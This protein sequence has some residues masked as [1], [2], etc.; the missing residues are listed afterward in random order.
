MIVMLSLIYFS[1]NSDLLL[2]VFTNY[3]DHFKTLTYGALFMVIL[4][5]ICKP[6]KLSKE[7][8]FHHEN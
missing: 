7:V 2:G 6:D 4:L 8:Q 3:F 1:E 5:A